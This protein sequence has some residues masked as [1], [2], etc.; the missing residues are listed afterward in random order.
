MLCLSNRP[1]PNTAPEPTAVGAFS[2]AVAVHVAS[3][4]CAQLSTFGSTEE[5]P[6]VMRF[7]AFLGRFLIRQPLGHFRVCGIEPLF[8]QVIAQRSPAARDFVAAS[9]V[10]CVEQECEEVAVSRTRR[11]TATAGVICT[12]NRFWFIHA[13]LSAPPLPPPAVG[14]LGSLGVFAHRA[15]AASLAAC[16][17]CVFV[18][19]SHRAL[20]PLMNWTALKT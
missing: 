1:Q 17:R 7:S 6:W 11:C 5:R 13:F 19:P 14:E 4:R 20:P 2:S 3:R 9:T 8:L 16:L 10:R 12:L 18:I 15:L